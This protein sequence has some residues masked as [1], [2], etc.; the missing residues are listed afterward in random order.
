MRGSIAH[1]GTQRMMHTRKTVALVLASSLTATILPSR[2]ANCADTDWHAIHPLAQAS[3][4]ADP[5][6]AHAIQP[7]GR[8]MLLGLSGA[9]AWLDDTGALVAKHAIEPL[10]DASI[11][12]VTNDIVTL[13][14]GGTLTRWPAGCTVFRQDPAADPV[15]Q[16]RLATNCPQWQVA[17]DGSAWLL[18][19]DGRNDHPGLLR[20]LA[21]GQQALRISGQTMSFR[22]TRLVSSMG[23][24][25]VVALVQEAERSALIR[26]N[27]LG[28]VVDRWMVPHDHAGDSHAVRLPV[29]QWLLVSHAAAG[30]HLYRSAGSELDLRQ[31]AVIDVIDT[32]PLR[33][34]SSNAGH[35]G[36]VDVNENR[37][38]EV[39]WLG[40]DGQLSDLAFTSQHPACAPGFEL[41]DI[42]DTGSV[43]VGTCAGYNADTIEVFHR[44]GRHTTH[45]HQAGEFARTIRSASLMANGWVLA[46][47][48]GDNVAW[49][50]PPLSDPAYTAPQPVS[51]DSRQPAWIEPY[52]AVVQDD[53]LVSAT[54]NLMQRQPLS[55]RHL[56]PTHMLA[57][58]PDGQTHWRQSMEETGPLQLLPAEDHLLAMGRHSRRSLSFADGAT[59]W[60]Q[61]DPGAPCGNL[62]M[63]RVDHE[64]VRVC[65]TRDMQSMPGGYEYRYEAF[66]ADGTRRVQAVLSDE[67]RPLALATDDAAWFAL[68]RN[69]SSVMLRVDGNGVDERWQVDGP[70]LRLRAATTIDG[71][72]VILRDAAL[73]RRDD[74][75]GLRWRTTVLGAEEAD[76][77]PVHLARSQL[78]P[79][80]DGSIAV[81]VERA[82]DS[83]T[84]PPDVP[85]QFLA[86]V[87]SAGVVAWRHW[88]Q[89]SPGGRPIRP[90][91]SHT[92]RDPQTRIMQTISGE[93]V[94]AMVH[95]EQRKLAVLVLDSNDG[96]PLADYELACAGECSAQS[97][98][99]L[100]DERLVALSVAGQ[101]LQLL[102]R[103]DALR[104]ASSI[105]IPLER[106][107]PDGAWYDPE[108][109][110]QGFTLRYLPA[111]GTVFMPWFTYA[112]GTTGDYD[113]A[114]QRWYTLQAGS[115][116]PD[117]S[118]ALTI[119][120]SSGGIFDQ[121]P[122]NPPRVVGD[123]TLRAHACDRLSLDY[124]FDQGE[125]MGIGGTVPLRRLLPNGGACP[126]GP[127][128]GAGT[129]RFD[130]AISGL[131]HDPATTG[132]GLDVYY[133]PSGSE[134]PALLFGAW[135]VFPPSEPAEA[136]GQTRWLTLQRVKAESEG[137][138]SA[139]I[140]QSLGGGLDHGLTRNHLRIGEVQLTSQACDRLL[141]TYR[142][143][144]REEAGGFAGRD[145]HIHLH[146]IGTCDN[147]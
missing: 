52:L 147:R 15:W 81:Y 106:I 71:D 112:S 35:I 16:V 98:R 135:F 58:S 17:S 104:D 76:A 36:L 114:H 5:V 3:A 66:A 103:D 47:T 124:R 11:E 101:D 97:I 128:P 42:T 78:F 95:E 50:L 9:V 53:L 39:R 43:L 139:E 116:A 46:I 127:D 65:G 12:R 49:R 109:D 85:I 10:A 83:F 82:N 13:A 87:D 61:M 118:T 144:Q 60:L 22:P 19:Q 74:T 6:I 64:T 115:F 137:S 55:E 21:D 72:L 56:W 129:R 57:I 89:P 110:G 73:E 14:D 92:N 70:L 141:L 41:T 34:L 119:H 96:R 68:E 145:G 31:I 138:L 136:A 7:D 121:Q 4:L 27:H 54:E 32:L 120:E 146:R 8:L 37:H 20:L 122:A 33:L 132:Q 113:A 125:H 18:T 102:V 94:V 2:P 117:G 79:L 48:I 67:S 142:F 86:R 105:S 84:V 51:P 28:D 107:S 130:T 59:R 30:L 77:V 75:G 93:L 91:I 45:R 140:W 90:R 80:S 143:D 63:K 126:D 1:L 40:A 38:Y 69:T 44:D 62:L 131:W 111:S 23:D 100:D 88:W 99:V 24:G 134:Q 26:I 25:S 133:A 123:A 108:T 29:G